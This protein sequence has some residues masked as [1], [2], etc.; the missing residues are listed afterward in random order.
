MISQHTQLY[1]FH[2]IISVTLITQ[3]NVSYCTG[4]LIS[5]CR[6]HKTK[7]AGLIWATTQNIWETLEWDDDNEEEVAD[8][9]AAMR[10]MNN[11]NYTQNT[12][13]TATNKT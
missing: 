3:I 5:Y 4:I 1:W 10:C 11:L 2:H 9:Q 12:V 6:C 13:T 8:K 7:E